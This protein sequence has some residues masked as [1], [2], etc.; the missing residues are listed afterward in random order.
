MKER[1]HWQ[2]FSGGIEQYDEWLVLRG[3]LADGRAVELGDSNGIVSFGRGF[4]ESDY[5]DEYIF[6]LNEAQS[7]LMADYICKAW[8]APNRLKDC[9]SK[10][11]PLQS[12]EVVTI[13][14]T[15]LVSEDKLH[16]KKRGPR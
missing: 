1:S 15:T 12:V 16:F 11:L 4:N 8:N 3:L 5:M 13:E 6:S 14:D 9:V 2:M 10:C 7:K